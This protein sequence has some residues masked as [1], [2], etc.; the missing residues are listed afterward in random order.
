M[1]VC[2]ICSGRLFYSVGPAV[3]KQRSPNWLCDLVAVRLRDSELTLLQFRRLKLFHWGQRRPVTVHCRA[4]YKCVHSLTYLPIG[5]CRRLTWWTWTKTLWCPS[6]WCTTSRKDWR[7]SVDPTTRLSRRTFSWVDHTS[8][9]S[10]VSSTTKTV[11]RRVSSLPLSTRHVAT[12]LSYSAAVT[13]LSDTAVLT[14][15]IVVLVLALQLRPL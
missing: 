5:V 8:L 9:T 15:I 13:T 12:T 11:R 7:A 2:R 10:I 3:A 14:L 1:S 4:L 6:V